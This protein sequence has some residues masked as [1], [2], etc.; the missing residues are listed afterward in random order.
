LL[1]QITPRNLK[2]IYF[3][4][5]FVLLV[6]YGS[7]FD[8][9]DPQSLKGAR[10][11]VGVAALELLRDVPAAKSEAPD[12]FLVTLAPLGIGVLEPDGVRFLKERDIIYFR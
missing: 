9:H 1:L 5:R 4:L 7:C 10:D 8:T 2:K 3:D 12:V 11:S 6:T